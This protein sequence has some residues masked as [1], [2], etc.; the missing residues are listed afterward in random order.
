[1]TSF[2]PYVITDLPAEDMQAHSHKMLVVDRHFYRVPHGLLGV[3]LAT[4]G[5]QVLDDIVR[6]AAMDPGRCEA[7]LRIQD[8]ATTAGVF[9]ALQAALEGAWEVYSRVVQPQ[10]FEAFV[11]RVAGLKVWGEPDPDNNGEPFR[12]QDGEEDSHICLMDLIEE[13]RATMEVRALGDFKPERQSP[14]IPGAMIMIRMAQD[15]AASQ[16]AAA[17]KATK[18]LRP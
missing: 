7:F 5:S 1:M 8:T 4:D 3:A 15:F 6:L 17:P 12:P 18:A 14:T 11:R 16:R 9:G 10:N 13:A 2:I